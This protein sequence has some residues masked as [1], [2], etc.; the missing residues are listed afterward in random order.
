MKSIFALCQFYHRI[1]LEVCNWKGIGSE[2]K[3]ISVI[4]IYMF[5]TENRIFIFIKMLFY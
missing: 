2:K 4:I 1:F 5:G 3:V